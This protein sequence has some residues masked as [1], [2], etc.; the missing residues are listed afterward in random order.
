MSSFVL[1]LIL[2]FSC[3]VHDIPINYLLL[4]NKSKTLSVLKNNGQYLQTY[5][6]ATGNFL[7]TSHVVIF[8]FGMIKN[9][10]IGI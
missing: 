3:K 1:F 4:S 8:V 7:E 10:I 6:M 9:C 5:W 2:S